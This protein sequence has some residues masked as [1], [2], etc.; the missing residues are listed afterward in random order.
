MRH[1]RSAL[2]KDLKLFFSGAGLLSLALPLLLLPALLFGMGDLAG[3][4]FLKSFP[5]A[6]HDEDQT[7][8]S[9]SLIS[10]IRHVELFSEVMVLDDT[11]S[12]ADAI[13]QGAAAVVTIP[14]DFFYDLY[15]MEE[16]PVSVTLNGSM[17]LQASLFE[18]VLESVMEIIRSDH[19]AGQG[20]YQY[21]YGTLTSHQ[22]GEMYEQTGMTLVKDALGRQQVFS[23][24]AAVSDLT[25]ALVRRLSATVLFILACYFSLAAVRT[26]PEET[27]LG[28][29]PRLQAAGG[30]RF[31]FL[32]SKYLTALLLTLPTFAAICLL[33]PDQGI[34]ELLVLH[35]LLLFAAF[36]LQLALA[37]WIQDPSAVQRLGNLF[38]LSNLVL[39]GTLW[40]RQTLPSLL[41][42]LSRFT[43]PY[44]GLLGLEAIHRE[45]S[46]L[47]LIWPLLVIGSLGLGLSCVGSRYRRAFPGSNGTGV[48]A[49]MKRLRPSACRIAGMS[50]VKCRSMVG[51]AV[52]CAIL[53]A[54]LL[55]C[56][57]AANAAGTGADSLRLAV[58]DLDR[59]STSEELVR[60]LQETEGLT[61]TTVSSAQGQRS[62]MLGES[63]G[64]LT[65]GEGYETQ[66]NKEEALPL[67]Y[68]SASGTISSQGGREIIAGQVM[69]QKARTRAVHQAENLLGRLLTQTDTADL[70]DIIDRYAHE[71]PSLYH[72]STLDG[73]TISEPFVPDQMAYCV[74][75]MLFVLLTAAPWCGGMDARA[76]AIRLRS[77]PHGR[78]LSLGS[79]CL[80][81]LSL[82]LMT[83]VCTLLPTG[84]ESC[85]RRLP[86]LLASSFCCSTLSLLLTRLSVL[87][88]RVDGLAPVVALI[89]CLLGGCFLDL[90]QLST[91]M[92]VVALLTPTGLA[93]A[94]ADGALGACGAL[95]VMGSIFLM[96]CIPSKR[97]A[98]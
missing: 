40:P 37:A 57:M 26:L 49:E 58:C 86:V 64:L 25:G 92:K 71:A 56:G 89:L 13:A 94:A 91:T 80:A 60:R 82:G 29:I 73:G 34:G 55:L 76:A 33:L 23:E 10:Q 83:G 96:A 46:M 90:S 27:S 4:A 95:V 2:Y 14:E 85:L 11:V 1:L 47:S 5:I 20:V 30:S 19:A 65:I 66:L 9:A 77:L 21:C 28:V 18:A 61:V 79:D 72:V 8:M 7:L 69:A 43:L 15:L 67:A 35:S 63:E 88:G 53:I 52:G 74:L 68:E 31:A 22:L 38:L 75:A 32:L 17:P 41:F 81:L 39:G 12:D 70:M 54:V 6:V 16:C 78:V 87:E 48:E 62:L 51:G 98:I 3:S 59:S 44:Y 93:M 97:S 24:T 42:S 45:V 84:W 36:G 50:A